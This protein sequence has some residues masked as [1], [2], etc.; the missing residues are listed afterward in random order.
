MSSQ[1]WPAYAILL[2]AILALLL[3]GVQEWR[4][5]GSCG[6]P[7]DDSWIHFQFARNVATGHG[8]SYN[9]GDE[10]PGSTS[11]L[12]VYLLA[13]VYRLTGEFVLTAKVLGFLF[14]LVSVWGIYRIALLLDGDKRLAVLTALV[15]VISGRLFWGALSGMEISLFTALTIAGVYVFVRYRDGSPASYLGSFILG[16]AA[17]ARPEGAALFLG[18]LC[19]YAWSIVRRRGH[20]AV[21]PTAGRVFAGL[22]LHLVIFSALVLP[23]VLF[24]HMTT[25]H[26]LPN[27]FYAKTAASQTAAAMLLYP[28]KVAYSFFCDQPL[29][30]LMLPFGLWSILRKTMAGDRR[31]LIPLFWFI[32]FPLVNA[33]VNPVT[34]HH[35]RYWMF[36]IPFY[37]LFSVHG[38]HWICSRKL[39]HAVPARMAIG[40]LSFVLSIG[41]LYHWSEEYSRNVDNIQK[42]DVR[43]G[44]WLADHLPPEAV[45]AASDVGAIGFFSGHTIID[46]DGLVTAE[47]IPY[48]REMGR[49]KGVSEFLRRRKPDFV[50]AFV[51]EFQFLSTEADLFEPI[52]SIRVMKNTILGGE[53]MAVY[54][55][56]WSAQ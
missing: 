41:I 31:W 49:E 20:D 14:L 38:L 52:F 23:E 5:A 48:L 39:L 18:M 6:V 10:T 9:P 43:M 22:A 29:L 45:V 35:G 3:F 40:A 4:Q 34:W 36:L 42:M 21:R 26:P 25:G 24:C 27:T 8:F 30:F 46:T 19:V 44:R 1:S 28:A 12:W 15:T 11:P 13:G 16:L 54:E 7:L 55:A 53:K 32:G 47:I 37:L 2:L 51:D 56:H 17:L 50:V 33:V